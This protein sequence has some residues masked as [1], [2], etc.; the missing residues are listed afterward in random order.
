MSPQGKYKACY[1][2]TIGGKVCLPPLEERRHT[3]RGMRSALVE[4]L[5]SAR[6]KTRRMGAGAK[7]TLKRRPDT[8]ERGQH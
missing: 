5:K 4:V 2:V 7:V 1:G 3:R 6:A 8:K